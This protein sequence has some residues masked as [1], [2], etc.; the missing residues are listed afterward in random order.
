MEV[1]RAKRQSNDEAVAFSFCYTIGAIFSLALLGF[2]IYGIQDSYAGKSTKRAQDIE[3]AIESWQTGG[4]RDI[5]TNALAF[6]IYETNDEEFKKE[7]A[8][9]IA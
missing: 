5:F 2:S 3:N 6:S 1:F 9:L 8:T 4:Q 7:N